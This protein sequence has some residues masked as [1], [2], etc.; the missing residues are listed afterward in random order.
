MAMLRIEYEQPAKNYFMD[1]GKLVF[2]LQVAIEGLVF[3]DGIP[4]EGEHTLLA[5]G[6]HLWS[7]MEHKVVYQI[8][9]NMLIVAVVAPAE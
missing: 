3:T 7:V 6:F 4:T 5:D 8:E 1:N 2:D 9:G